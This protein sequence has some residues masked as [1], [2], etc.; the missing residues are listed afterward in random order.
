VLSEH[1]LLIAH[2]LMM[3]GVLAFA[4]SPVL[5]LTFVANL[6][7][8]GLPRPWG[9]LAVAVP[10]L[11]GLAW[12][13]SCLALPSGFAVFPEELK[14]L[15]IRIAAVL[16]VFLVCSVLFLRYLHLFWSGRRHGDL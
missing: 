3:G 12:L 6:S 8:K 10:V 13:F 16:G 1:S 11:Y 14:L 7:P 15:P 2:L 5:L 9:Y 4:V